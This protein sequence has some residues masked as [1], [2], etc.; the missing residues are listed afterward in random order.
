MFW[1]NIRNEI[2]MEVY[3]TQGFLTNEPVY[4]IEKWKKVI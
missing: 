1:E 2:P 4:V 3:D